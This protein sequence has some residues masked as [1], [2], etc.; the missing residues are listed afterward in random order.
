MTG[1][2]TP[3][4]PYLERWTWPTGEVQLLFHCPAC[5]GTHAYWLAH[6]EGHKG[7]VWEFNGSAERPSFTPSLRIRSRDASGETCCHLYVTDGQIRYCSDCT[8]ELADKTVP[9]EVVL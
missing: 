7:P 1:E 3:F 6:P 8:H 9:M 4:G 2:S 5:D